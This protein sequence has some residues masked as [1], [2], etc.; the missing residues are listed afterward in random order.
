MIRREEGEQRALIQ[1]ADLHPWGPDLIAIP[2][3][4]ALGYKR[5]IMSAMGVRVGVS[6][7]FLSVPMAK[8]GDPPYLRRPGL[9]IELKAKGGRVSMAQADWL[10]RKRAQGY[11]A[12]CCFSFEEAKA[13]IERYLAGEWEG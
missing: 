8:A 3:G 2:N 9:W 11:A 13:A 4:H 7:L 10:L 1:W 6:D 5:G 12:E